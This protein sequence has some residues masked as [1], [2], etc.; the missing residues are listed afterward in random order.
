MCKYPNGFI[1]QDIRCPTNIV[2]SVND[3]GVNAYDNYP[4][5]S[6]S[7]QDCREISNRTSVL[8]VSKNEFEILEFIS[9]KDD[10]DKYVKICRDLSIPVRSLFVESEYYGEL[11]KGSLPQLHFIG[12]EY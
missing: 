11:W 1:V 4:L 10:W 12:Y 6:I 3:K 9:H 8:E 5:M 7:T 2:K